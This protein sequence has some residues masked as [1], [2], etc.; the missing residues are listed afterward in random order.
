MAVVAVCSSADYE[1]LASLE[2]FKLLL[3][4]TTTEDDDLMTDILNRATGAVESY[5][6]RP[7]RR[8]TYSE[9]V[10]SYGTM[11]LQ[12]SNTPVQSIA[13][14]LKDDYLVGST[15]Y[16]IARAD[17][18]TIYRPYG[19][20]WTAGTI[21]DLVPH[22]MPGTERLSFVIEYEGGYVQSTSTSTGIGTPR[23]LEQATM[24]VGK[25]W[26]LGRNRNPL[27]QSKSVGDLK[28]EYGSGGRTATGQVEHK[29]PGPALALLNDF[30]RVV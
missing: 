12:V 17:A 28:I 23:S 13:R 5:L 10:A 8:Q 7:L 18:G 21:T 24:E 9:K 27:V 25:A 16:E 2:S 22:A 4:T 1:S 6:G 14:I 19:W 20:S 3:G 30:Q 11:F 26:Y 15:E 29:L